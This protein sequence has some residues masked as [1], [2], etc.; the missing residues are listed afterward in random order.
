[1]CLWI[2]VSWR[3]RT[4]N[5]VWQEWKLWIGM[6]VIVLMRESDFC[7]TGRERAFLCQAS[8]QFNRSKHN[9]EGWDQTKGGSN[10]N[11]LFTRWSR[12]SV[13]CRSRCRTNRDRWITFTDTTL[14]GSAE[15]DAW[16]SSSLVNCSL[17]IA[18]C[19]K[20]SDNPEP[21]MNH[22]ISPPLS[23]PIDFRG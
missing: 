18:R 20:C 4:F 15:D 16:R 9:T 19:R 17:I 21:F 5:S 13:T 11:F 8:F 3:D 1:M 14:R 10:G 12:V 2:S 22:S 7:L 23:T 6:A